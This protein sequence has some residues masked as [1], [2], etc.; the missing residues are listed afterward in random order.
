MKIGKFLIPWWCWAGLVFIGL[1]AGGFFFWQGYLG[2]RTC[3]KNWGI[4]EP[5]KIYRA[6]QIH[7]SLIRQAL[8]QHNIKVIISLNAFDANDPQQAAEDE[9]AR[10][11]GIEMIRFAFK[12][13]G[14]PGIQPGDDGKASTQPVRDGRRAYARAVAQIVKAVRA[15]RPVLVHCSAGTH[16]TGG[17]IAAYRLL[18]E[19]KNPDET[20]TELRSYG[21]DPDKHQVLADYLNANLPGIAQEL[22]ALGA[23]DSPPDPIPVLCRPDQTHPWIWLV[24]GLAIGVAAGVA[25]IL[26]I[27][28]IRRRTAA[29]KAGSPAVPQGDSPKGA[30]SAPPEAD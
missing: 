3:P 26:L 22:V 27:R 4:V 17:V 13:N 19:K 21:W 5:G 25:L 12:G 11:L 7:P 15:G 30:S 2:P 10:E 1:C 8:Q 9:I 23:I 14:T 16:R 18:V 20:Y 6:G 28:L 29:P 24:V